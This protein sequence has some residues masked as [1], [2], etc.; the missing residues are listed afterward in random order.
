MDAGRIRTQVAEL[1]NFKLVLAPLAA[2]QNAGRR[3]TGW[4]HAWQRAVADRALGPLAC[5][6][7]FPISLSLWQW[8]NQT[9]LTP[10]SLKIDTI[11]SAYKMRVCA[12]QSSRYLMYL[13]V[14]V[15]NGFPLFNYRHM[16][17]DAIGHWGITAQG[18]RRESF[19]PS[20]A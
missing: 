8:I 16:T 4:E 5:H 1:I 14:A 9:F 6:H 17:R 10:L 19:V 2:K 15:L 12:Y 18:Q 7:Y 20:P 3:G 11:S 13:T